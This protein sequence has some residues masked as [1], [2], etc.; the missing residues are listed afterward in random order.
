V[1]CVVSEHFEQH[2]ER[3]RDEKVEKGAGPKTWS[4]SNAAVSVSFDCKVYSTIDR[5]KHCEHLKYFSVPF[6]QRPINTPSVKSH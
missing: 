6:D 2:G 1:W 3:G 5:R 4:P